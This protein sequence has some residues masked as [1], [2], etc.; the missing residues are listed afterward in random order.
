MF[1]VNF[2]INTGFIKKYL[3]NVWIALH[4]N[5]HSVLMYFHHRLA[6]F[7]HF[8]F[9]PSPFTLL[10]LFSFPFFSKPQGKTNRMLESGSVFLINVIDL[11]FV[12][13]IT[14][15]PI[16]SPAAYTL[17]LFLLL[18]WPFSFFLVVIFIVIYIV[19]CFATSKKLWLPHS[20][21]KCFSYSYT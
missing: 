13:S 10:H 14:S 4:T 3:L 16:T 18:C 12:V 11:S 15:Q 7:F 2:H 6:L 5:R 9:R 20:P 17:L 1:T 21:P 8:N 19:A